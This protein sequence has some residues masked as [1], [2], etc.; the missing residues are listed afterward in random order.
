MLKNM[1]RKHELNR[2][3][4]IQKI[5]AKG[6]EPR[7]SALKLKAESIRKNGAIETPKHNT[8]LMA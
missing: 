5:K 8:K 7:N 3:A 1:M 6:T 2:K 4:R